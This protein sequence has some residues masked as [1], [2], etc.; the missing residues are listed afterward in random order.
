MEVTI[1]TTK[2]M[3]MEL[4]MEFVNEGL[5]YYAHQPYSEYGCHID[6]SRV[7]YSCHPSAG[8]QDGPEGR[9]KWLDRAR[10]A[11]EVTWTSSG[12][13]FTAVDLERCTITYKGR[14]HGMPA[15]LPAK[16]KECDVIEFT[17]LSDAPWYKMGVEMNRAAVKEAARR[18]REAIRR[19]AEKGVDARVKNTLKKM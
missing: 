13:N 2:A 18:E 6:G 9:Q 11:K 5:G 19:E 12:D 1:K 3:A 8:W 14:R 4:A 16:F 10:V 17:S 15:S 7:Q